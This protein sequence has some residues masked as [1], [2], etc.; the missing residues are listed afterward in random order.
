M[1]VVSWEKHGE[2]TA[3]PYV[4]IF[5]QREVFR[6]SEIHDDDDDDDDDDDHHHHHHHHYLYPFLCVSI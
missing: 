5:L 6:Q 3:N 1:V 2:M 4:S